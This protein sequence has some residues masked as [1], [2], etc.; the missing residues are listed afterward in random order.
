MSVTPDEARDLVSKWVFFWKYR[1]DKIRELSKSKS[2]PNPNYNKDIGGMTVT[3]SERGL[4]FTWEKQYIQLEKLINEP[5]FRL[6]ELGDVRRS[7]EHTSEL[8]SHL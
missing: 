8:Q 4:E 7:E 3:L 1:W 6:K 5:K 2:V